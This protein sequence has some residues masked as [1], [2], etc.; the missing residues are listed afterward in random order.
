MKRH[1]RVC[2]FCGHDTFVLAPAA[3]TALDVEAEFS[4]RGRAFGTE[5]EMVGV[6][7]P[8]CSAARWREER[9]LDVP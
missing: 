7:C 9:H 6:G 8:T 4:S 1:I 3:A 5:D 2:M